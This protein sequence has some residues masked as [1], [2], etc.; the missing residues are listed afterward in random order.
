MSGK[1]RPRPFVDSAPSSSVLCAPCTKQ[2]QRMKKQFP[3][4]KVSTL[5]ELKEGGAEEILIQEPS[6][7]ACKVH[8]QPMSMYCYDCDT[9]IC[10][11]CTIKDH[12]DHNYEFVLVAA[13]KT[14]KKCSLPYHQVTGSVY[15]IL[16]VHRGA[17]APPF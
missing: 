4:H 2:H 3:G 13:P 5:E 8:K 15:F 6:H 10:R 14:K 1:T 11:D 9:L 16:K 12:R 7:E 17:Q